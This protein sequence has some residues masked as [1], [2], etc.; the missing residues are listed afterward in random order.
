MFLRQM[1]MGRRPNAPGRGAG[2]SRRVPELGRA[3]IHYSCTLERF[4]Q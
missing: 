1:L 3:A 4:W 2:S